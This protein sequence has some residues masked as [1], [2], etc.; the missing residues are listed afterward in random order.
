MARDLS[1]IHPDSPLA[2][3]T[4]HL[5]KIKGV[6]CDLAK[7]NGPATPA[8]QAMAEYIQAEIDH[9]LELLKQLKTA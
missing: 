9:V 6:A 8:A 1:L 4:A 2:A 7:A 5:E 3:A